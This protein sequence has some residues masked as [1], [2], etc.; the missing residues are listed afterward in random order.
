M[1]FEYYKFDTKGT[2][3]TATQKAQQ[4]KAKNVAHTVRITLTAKT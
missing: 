3:M 1:H 4:A 2:S